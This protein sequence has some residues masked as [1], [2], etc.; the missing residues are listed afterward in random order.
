MSDES[1]GGAPVEGEAA[2]TQG[3]VMLERLYLKDASFESPR[4]PTVFTETWKPE[5]QLDINTRTSG[6]GEDRFEVILSA[7]L[8][9][10]SEEDSARTAYIVEIQQAGVFHV[11]GLDDEARQRVLGTLCPGTLFPYIRETVDSLVV[12]GGFPA[13]HLAPVNFEALYAEALRKQAGEA[14]SPTQH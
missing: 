13:V 10:R 12:K 6:L 1:S 7:T 11:S 9:A 2:G 14:G 8:R 3:Q 5:F 4:S